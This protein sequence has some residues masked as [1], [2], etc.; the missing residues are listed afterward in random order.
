MSI[1][2]EFNGTNDPVTCSAMTFAPTYLSCACDPTKMYSILALLY[3]SGALKDNQGPAFLQW[4]V[5]NISGAELVEGFNPYSSETCKTFVPWHEV[6]LDWW[7]HQYTQV[8]FLVFEQK[9]HVTDIHLGAWHT[10][11]SHFCLQ[12]FMLQQ[13]ALYGRC[14]ETTDVEVECP[15]MQHNH[16]AVWKRH[17]SPHLPSWLVETS[18]R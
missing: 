7:H 2:I 1:D 9:T 11:R 18:V 15:V 13:V 14:V 17:L 10:R 12:T 6:P 8:R 3:N 4:L 5:G 16:V